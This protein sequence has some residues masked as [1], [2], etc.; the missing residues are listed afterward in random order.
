MDP[1]TMGVERKMSKSDPTSAITIPATPEEVRERL[2]GAFCPAKEVDGNPVVELASFVVFPWEGRLK[3]DRAEKHGG[4]L[5]FETLEAFD[6]A[7]R[8]GSIH[9]M[10]LKNAVGEALNRIL[11]GS[12]EFFQRQPDALPSGL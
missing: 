10:D 5:D 9:P 1:T 3:I 2:K 11:A 12:T 4:A 6:A 7:W 8:A